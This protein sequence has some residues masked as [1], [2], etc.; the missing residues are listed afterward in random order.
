MPADL[1]IKGAHQLGDLAKR[2]KAEGE[3]GKGLR[4]ELLREIRAG[5]KPLV[6]DA[7]A[8]ILAMPAKG[9][10]STGL[11]ARIAKQIKV[12]VRLAGKRTGVRISIG[13]VPDGYYL[14]RRINKGSWKHPVHGDQETWVEQSGKKGWFD[15]TL[16]KG[17]PKVRVRL[18]TA[19][20]NVANRIEKG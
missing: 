11:R 4:K 8:A 6:T 1:R 5:A 2:L 16:T 20:R 17:A 13:Q 14:P 10:E 18:L 19:M 9:P 3:A 12:R 7:R 15:N